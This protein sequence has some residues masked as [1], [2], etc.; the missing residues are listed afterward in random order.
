MIETLFMVACSGPCRRYL[1]CELGDWVAVP[2]YM[3]D[4]FDSRAEAEQ[5]ARDAGWWPEPGQ[6][7]ACP[8]CRAAT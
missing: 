6:P 5:A 2:D 7:I 8:Q 3:R 4:V 1:A